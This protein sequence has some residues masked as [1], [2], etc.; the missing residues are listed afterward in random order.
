MTWDGGGDEEWLTSV[1]RFVLVSKGWDSN[2]PKESIKD[3][4]LSKP[5]N[6][7][8]R[9]LSGTGLLELSDKQIKTIRIVVNEPDQVTGS[10]RHLL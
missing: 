9:Q 5:R 8:E 3:F 7:Y 2:E 4:T 6:T 10:M 1:L